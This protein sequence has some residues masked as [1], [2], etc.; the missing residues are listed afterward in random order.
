MKT[1]R[2]TPDQKKDPEGKRRNAGDKRGRRNNKQRIRYVGEKL[3]AS[4]L[5]LTIEEAFNIN[6]KVTQ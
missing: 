6:P 1:L 4:R 3:K 5:Y 2:V